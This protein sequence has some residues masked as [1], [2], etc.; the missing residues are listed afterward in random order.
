M[1]RPAGRSSTHTGPQGEVLTLTDPIDTGYLCA[2]I[3]RCKNTSLKDCEGRTLRQRCTT[4]GIWFDEEVNQLVW[5]YKAE[6]GYN[7]KVS[8]PAPLMSREQPN[9]PSRF[10]LGR[11]VCE[12]LLKR[13]FEG[14]PQ[15]GLVRIPDCIILKVTGADLAAMRAAGTIDWSR[16]I[17]TQ[18][19]IDT[20]VEIKFD[21]DEL[22]N[23]QLLSYRKIAGSVEKFRLLEAQDCDCGERPKPVTV[24]V[25]SPVTTPMQRESTEMRRWYQ[26]TPPKPVPVPA[27]QPVRPQYGPVTG[28]EEGTPLADHLKTAAVVAG[29]ILVGII[30]VEL[31]PVGAVVVGAARLIV[32]AAGAMKTAAAAP[33]TK[34]EK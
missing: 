33:N 31:I 8:P 28:K 19:N 11:A 14:G 20:V 34:K 26:P 23:E 3:C 25:R 10:P 1:A 24:P 13:D 12:G 27:P 17:P 7:M 30:A 6:V 2:H 18:S 15:K 16:L 5:R 4:Q 9:R 22:K 32:I 21:N 29:C